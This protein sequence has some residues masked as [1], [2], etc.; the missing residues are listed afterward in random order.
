MASTT[1]EFGSA[2]CGGS[3]RKKGMGSESFPSGSQKKKQH[4]VHG[5]TLSADD[6]YLEMQLAGKRNELQLKL[7]S[8][9]PKHGATFSRST[10]GSF[11]YLIR[12]LAI[13]VAYK[14][15]VHVLSPRIGVCVRALVLIFFLG[16]NATGAQ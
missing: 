16:C 5:K 15:L 1:E 11:V 9:S 8:H 7:R 2:G 4:N 13:N 14:Y 6:G 3:M 12:E 10:A